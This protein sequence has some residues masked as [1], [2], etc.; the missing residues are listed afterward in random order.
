MPRPE[1]LEAPVETLPGVGPAV[2]RKLGR[3]GIAT[4]GDLL[5]AQAYGVA[6]LRHP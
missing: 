6:A 5:L 3:L 4:V 2:R 1:R